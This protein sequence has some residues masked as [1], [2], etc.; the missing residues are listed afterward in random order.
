V[1]APERLY[2]NLT[3]GFSVI[4]IGFGVVIL[5]RTL[6]GGGGATST[7]LLLGL[8]FV[9]IGGARLYLALRNRR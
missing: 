7:G 9:G 1:S 8:L 2:R 5:A 4:I 6:G 3:L